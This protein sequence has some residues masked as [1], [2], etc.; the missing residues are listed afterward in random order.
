MIK[1]NSMHS[2]EKDVENF[3]LEVS[4]L[5]SQKDFDISK[6]FFLIKTKK[7]KIEFSTPYTMT[8]LEFDTQDVLDQISKLSVSE[9]SETLLDNRDEN[10][11]F[12]YV[13]GK[14]INGKLVYIK[15]KIKESYKKIL[16]CVSFHF[17]E[18][19]MDFPYK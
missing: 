1:F 5:I 3:L 16:L 17:A 15:I 6:D 12:L 11:P 2:K 4:T 8:E 10:P 9:Y 18:H 14:N 13:F 19:P 7:P